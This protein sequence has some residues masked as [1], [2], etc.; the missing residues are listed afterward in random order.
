MLRGINLQSRLAV[1]SNPVN[2]LQKKAQNAQNPERPEKTDGV[3]VEISDE[4]H[5]YQAR[6]VEAEQKLE[7]G[8]GAEHDRQEQ[9]EIES[10]KSRDQEVRTHEHAHAATGG[11][12]AGSPSY[13]Y[14]AG[15]DGQRYITGGE[16]SIDVSPVAGDPSATIGKMRMVQAAALAPAQPSGQDRAVASRA[17]RMIAKAQAQMH[18]KKQDGE[19]MEESLG[20]DLVV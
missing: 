12:H 4:A 1:H 8:E 10:L 18:E 19:P 17:M 3:R 9:Q 2:G 13:S 7:S 6:K 15:P 16:V 14:E 11:V 20:V 5:A